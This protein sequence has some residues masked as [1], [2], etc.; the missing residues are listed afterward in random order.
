MLHRLL[1]AK[2]GVMH[3]QIAIDTQ[4]RTTKKCA[5]EMSRR[6]GCAVL[7]PKPSDAIRA[8]T[9]ARWSAS[10]VPHWDC[11]MLNCAECKEYPVPAE[12]A[13]KDAGAELISFHVYECKVS[14]RK[15]GKER[16]RL[17]LVQKRTTIGEFHQVFFVA[18][19]GCGRYHMTSYKLAA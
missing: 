6:W 19:L 9:C 5:E 17:E 18:A 14:L 16:Q 8:G 4:R 7:H 2:R 13:R 11:Q 3:H 12:E 1:Q 15:D 10:N